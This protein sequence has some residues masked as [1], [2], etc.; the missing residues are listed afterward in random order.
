MLPTKQVDFLIVGQGLAGSCLAY[1]LLNAGKSVAITD[2]GSL[3][4]ASAVGAG[5]MNPLVFRYI[6]QSWR[7]ATYFHNAIAFY[8]SIE[9][10]FGQKLLHKHPIARLLAEHEFELWQSRA[11]E[12][13]IQLWT[14]AQLHF[15]FEETQIDYPYGAVLVNAAR[16]DMVMFAELMQAYFVA[17]GVFVS[18]S[19]DPNHLEIEKDGFVFDGIFAKNLAFCEGH[20]AVRNPLF[21]FVPFRP[22]KG[23]LLTLHISG[24][25]ENH[26]INRD[27]FVMPLGNNLFRVGSN[28]DWDDLSV[29]PTQ[30][31]CAYLLGKLQAFLK[32]PFE[33]VEHHAGIRPSVADRRPVVG[34]HPEFDNIFILNGLGAKGAMLA[35]AMTEQLL[36]L[37]IKG[38]EV[39][40][41]VD[42]GRFWR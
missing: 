39:D 7:A 14:D 26:I 10:E 2:Q 30:K 18:G 23:E 5:I 27:I 20:H 28:Y 32:L 21:N 4:A 40:V 42:V 33:V 25:P 37:M 11:R 38:V 31:T 15:P 29:E 9:K 22:V 19:F 8:Q 16:A 36:N 6:T 34:C 24:L 12:G 3:T 35:P 41:E 17:K 1:G 13:K